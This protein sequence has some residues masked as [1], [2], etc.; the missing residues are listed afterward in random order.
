MKIPDIAGAIPGNGQ[1]NHLHV[2]NQ[3]G[4][5]R[6][7]HRQSVHS[8]DIDLSDTV[9]NFVDF[10]KEGRYTRHRYRHNM[11]TRYRGKYH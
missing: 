9:N 4:D 2:P 5:M 8:Q 11:H 6:S 10:V 3:H 1:R 7:L